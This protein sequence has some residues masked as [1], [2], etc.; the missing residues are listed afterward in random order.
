M[1]ECLDSLGI[2]QHL[3]RSNFRDWLAARQVYSESRD[4]RSDRK[5]QWVEEVRGPF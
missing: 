4:K 1:K 2:E 5:M 3:F